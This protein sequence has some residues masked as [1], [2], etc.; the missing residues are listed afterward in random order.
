MKNY[1]RVWS[2]PPG[3]MRQ[4]SL[5]LTWP[6]KTIA[7]NENFYHYTIASHLRKAYRE[8]RRGSWSTNGGGW[9]SGIN[10][11]AARR[12]IFNTLFATNIATSVDFQATSPDNPNVKRT[13][14]Q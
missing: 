5:V 11:D 4:H 9:N 1:M 10:P 6:E 7:T 3:A 8:L 2:Y 13:P 12:V 14:I